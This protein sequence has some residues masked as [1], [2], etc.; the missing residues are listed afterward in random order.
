M[1]AKFPGTR[2]GVARHRLQ[3]FDPILSR[4][5]PLL[6]AV[7]LIQATLLLSTSPGQTTEDVNPLPSLPDTS[8]DNHGDGL[9]DTTELNLA[10]PATGEPE[11]SEPAAGNPTAGEPSFTLPDQ[12]VIPPHPALLDE[13]PPLTPVTIEVV[14][15]EVPGPIAETIPGELDELNVSFGDWLGYNT[16]Q[17]DMS[18]LG[19]SDF[20]MFSVESFPTLQLGEESALVAGTGFHFLNGP[21]TPDMPPRLFDLQLAYHSR[22]I[23]NDRL[24]L[25]VKLGI[26]AFSDFEGSARKGIRFPGHVVSY[27]E[28]N[29]R[30]ASVFGIDVLDRDD[31]SL[32]PVAGFVWRPNQDSVYELVFPR[33]KIQIRLDS[34]RAM[35]IGGELGG[36][37]WAIERN[38]TTND[39]ATYR[40]LQVTLGVMTFHS[41]SSSVLEI[42][43]SFDRHLEYRSGLGNTPF[44]DAFILRCRAHY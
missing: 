22:K 26:G 25:D 14:E 41:S 23:Q 1:K 3:E 30:L 37:T 10:K 28:W 38:G 5:V 21:T 44:D 42:G 40:D 18:W 36:G 33:P 11:V 4:H 15:P 8:T 19:G 43:W 13:P 24:I 16:M 31:I 7:S 9:P 17:S 12:A 34:H 20:G 29:H 35:Y 32:L 2:D 39:N 27:V 6:I